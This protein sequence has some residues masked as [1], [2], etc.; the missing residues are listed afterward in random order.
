MKGKVIL[1]VL[2]GAAI[3]A[4]LAIATWRRPAPTTV[5]DEKIVSFLCPDFTQAFLRVGGET[6]SVAIAATAEERAKGLSGCNNVPAGSGM[7]FTFAEPVE[8]KFWMK[9]MFIPIDIVWIRD[10]RVL[11]VNK[12]VPAP[13]AAGPG[14]RDDELP[15]YTAPGLIDAVLEL[16][17]GEA[18][19]LRISVDTPVSLQ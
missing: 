1:L 10:G 14:S 15:L 8:A 4:A 7:Y 17:A 19:R 3:I 6:L 2:A 5:A 11:G 16:P 18:D 13:P 9:G 12:N